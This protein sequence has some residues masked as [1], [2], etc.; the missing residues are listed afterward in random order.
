MASRRCWAAVLLALAAGCTSNEKPADQTPS[1]SA[2]STSTS[3]IDLRK[4]PLGRTVSEPTVGGLWAC[5]TDPDAGGAQSA[6]PWID[7]GA[8]T[9]DATRKI[10]V[11]GEKRWSN[12]FATAT[13][14][15]TRHITGNGLPDHTTGTFPVATSDAAYPY[16]RNPN[17]ITEQNDDIELPA[18]PAPAASPTCAGGEVGIML[19]GVRLFSAIDAPGRDAVA[20]EVQDRCGGH[21][22][23]TGRYHYHALST[24]IADGGTGH[25]KLVGY[26]FDGFGIYGY[27]GEDG[28]EL[29]NARLDV[30]HGHTHAIDWNGKRVTMFHYHATHEY[31]YTVGCMRA[32]SKVQLGG[33][34]QS[35][36]QPGEQPPPPRPGGQPLAPPP[37]QR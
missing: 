1:T 27:R 30:C 13:T 17:I 20:Y 36:G 29:T 8:N 25:S 11:S 18:N 12:R 26:A 35:A 16:D 31:P 21:P 6:G 23:R 28:K 4:L 24:C 3:S 34:T 19:S 22:E 9:W 5:R 10:S 2:L 14:N 37:P 15:D 7:E 32:A 33:R